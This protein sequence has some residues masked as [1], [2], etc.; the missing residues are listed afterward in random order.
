MICS[1]SFRKF[2]DCHF[3]LKN[4]FK[5]IVLSI[6]NFCINH[7]DS[8]CTT[9]TEIAEQC[10]FDAGNTC[11]G[12]TVVTAGSEDYTCTCSNDAYKLTNG[13]LACEISKCHYQLQHWYYSPSNNI[14]S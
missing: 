1:V 2:K 5:G 9:S 8:L 12:G 14:E 13:D 3:L 6:T 4:T 11:V 7:L 10:Q